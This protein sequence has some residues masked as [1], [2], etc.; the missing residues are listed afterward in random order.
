MTIHALPL[1]AFL[2]STPLL[3]LLTAAG[4][5]GVPIVIH[6]LNRRRFRIVH[7]AAMRF[8]LAAQRQNTRKLRLEQFLLLAVRTLI[9]LLLV[10]AM[11]GVMPWA[12]GFWARLFPESIVR[13]APGERR[14]HHIILLDGSFS[15]ATRRGDGTCF[16]HARQQ[17][18][19]IVQQAAAGDG[20][21]VLLM[22]APPRRIV[23]GPSQDAGR[24]LYEIDSVRLPHGNADLAGT[25]NAV[26]DLVRSSPG[27]FEEREV[28]FLTDLQRS[29]WSG[30]TGSNLSAV[31]QQLAGRARLIFVDS[32]QNGLPN[33]AV[34]SLTLGAPLATTGA[35]TPIGVTIH[36]YGAE[37]RHQVP[38]DLYVGRARTSAAD[39]PLALQRVREIQTDLSPGP[40]T[41]SFSYTFP[42]AGDYALQVRLA[43]DAL[44]LDDSRSAVVTVKDQVPVLLVNGKPANDI[45]ETASEWLADALNPYQPGKAPGNVPARP[46]IISESQFA[47]AAL[48]DLTPYDCV[49]LCDLAGLSSGE[50]HRLDT[51]LRRGGGIVFCLGPHVDLE[52][53]NRLLYRNG[54]G[55]LP[56][57]LI[58]RQQAPEQQFFNFFADEDSYHQP[59]LDAFAGERDRVGLL[60]AR[61]RQYIRVELA[62]AKPGRLGFQPDQPAG[63]VENLNYGPARARR[64]LSFVPEVRSGKPRTALETRPTSANPQNAT[65]APK[66]NDNAGRTALQSRPGPAA[67]PALIEW[68]RSRGRV[69]LFT[70]TVNMDWTAWPISPSFPALMQE[71]LRF[72]VAGRLREQAVQ[73]GEPLETYLQVGGAG[74]DVQFDA[75]EG[76]HE[77]A[78]TESADDLGVLRWTDTDTSG[79]YR[80]TIGQDPHDYLFAVNVPAAADAQEGSESDL[81]RTNADELHSLFP[82]ADF[83]IVTEPGQVRHTASS[84]SSDEI[85]RPTTAL[86]TVLARWLLLTMVVLLVAEVILA[87]RFGYYENAAAGY[88]QPSDRVRR[89]TAVVPVLLA[90]VFGVVFLAGGFVL[91]H[92]AW[93]G[94]VLSF[95]PASL[96][97]SI[98]ARLGV[99]PPPA[100]EGT[101][102]HLEFTPYLWDA[103]T[104]PWL[105]GT[106]AAGMAIL[107]AVI[108]RREGQIAGR[109]YK[110]LLAGLRL[111]LVLLT[112]TVLLPQLRLRFEREGWPDVA[113]LI[114]DS[115][116]MSTADRYQDPRVQEAADRLV[117]L[118]RS[119][120]P[121]IANADRLRLAQALLTHDQHAWLA[122]LLAGRR[123]KL[124]I[125]HCS[126][127]AA[128]LADASAPGELD[129]AER[130]IRGLKADGTSSQLGGAVRQVLGDFR[131]SSLAALIMLTDGVTTEGE[132]LV[133]ASRHAARAGVPLF[134]IGLGDAHEARDLRLHDLQVEDSVYVNDR[135]IFE[136]RLTAQGYTDGRIVPIQLYE[137]LPDGALKKLGAPE[138]VA[139]DPDGKPVKFRL[140]YQPTEPGEK[141]FVLIAQ[142]QTDETGST[143]NNRLERT[144]TVRE[145]K[146]IRVLYIEGYPRYEFRYL[147]NLLE[148]EN[149]RDPRNKTMDL[150]VLL[151]DSDSE[152]A[153]EDRSAL[154]DFPT[155]EEL[156]GYDVVILG[157]CDPRDPKLGERNLRHLA[158]FV[159][160]RGGGLLMIAGS[161][162]SPHAYH[163]GPLRD[164]LPIQVTSPP[165]ADVDL[166][167]PFHPQLT[168][169]GRFHPIFRFNPDE[170]GNTAI[171]SHLAPLYW[172]SEGFRTQPAAEVLLLHPGGRTD[173]EIRPTPPAGR[174]DLQIR[175]SA[176]PGET[177]LPLAVQQFVGAGRSLFFGFDESWRWRFREDE[178]HYNQFWIQTVRYLARSRLGRIDL[179]LDRQASYRRGEPIRVTVRFPDDAPAPPPDTRVEVLAARRPPGGAALE[180]ETLRLARVEGSRATFEGLLTRTPD[181]DY[182]FWLSAP[183]VPDP[184]PHA[185]ARVLPPPGELEQL[186][187]NQPDLERAADETHGK[188]YTLADIDRL[189]D[190]LPAGA[191]LTLSTP[192]PPRLLWNHYAVFALALALLASEWALRKRKHLL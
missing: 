149:D 184:R 48:G 131:G 190:D 51:H 145:S 162:Y 156:N 45:Y 168:A 108:Y 59:P 75:P 179:R 120:G 82:G 24:V 93:T 118:P 87:W 99:P 5:A 19:R 28:Y 52:A 153:S 116:S 104:D 189:I 134:F 160:E 55:L 60:L 22:A 186:R 94:D 146:L 10:L 161:R 36:H 32:G 6:L 61:F 180:K 57:R 119:A 42:I 7:W 2:F 31:V 124:H 49:F 8:L 121:G 56:A 175:P 16:E 63:Q 44:D 102:W 34:T 96:R 147:K 92:A 177:G 154:A 191:R 181:G 91:A 30:R 188:F 136:A 88:F 65:A 86:G 54:Q 26:A 159:E 33:T 67:D 182:Q 123:V 130:A 178:G 41:L 95:L 18:R 78:Q 112:L 142:P 110:L 25:L 58:G 126:T 187:M 64:I 50:V 98:E 39:P 17:A 90:L 109:G 165:A 4:A 77:F 89:L 103:A 85:E 20:F 176:E 62:T 167:T 132:D 73:V 68:T 192:Q 40:N 129:A 148:R 27:R 138:L 164:V 23:P 157:D 81:T 1:F 83:Q 185:E 114:D 170:A 106:F 13:A 115:A 38:V 141:T 166:K 105:A 139:T 169:V 152:Y 125:Y 76:R 174:T 127:R 155:R 14:T 29:T 79:L 43:P 35:A 11:A 144:V 47:D 107:V 113:I 12:E 80:A 140:V 111:L 71:L 21:S 183:A 158:E 69:L 172:W 101:H 151:L 37:P 135:L 46:R 70:S 128:R 150:K 15:M 173:L 143:D 122:D 66:V 9:V 117:Q 74:L 97:S 133:K 163:G 137:K 84:T 72:A 3:A 171:W 53:Y 100:G